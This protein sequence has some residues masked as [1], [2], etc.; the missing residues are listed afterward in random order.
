M[1]AD[2]PDS[3][4]NAEDS[5]AHL[6]RDLE[7]IARSGTESIDAR[8]PNLDQFTTPDLVAA[9]V[10]DQR[11]AVEAVVRAASAIS[12]AVDQAVVR[13]SR[14]GRLIYAG[15]GTSGRLAFLDA[16]EL[17]PTFS[18][19][20]SRALVCMAGGQDA[21]FKAV[22][23]AEDNLEAGRADVSRLNPAQDD[24]IIGIA[25]SGTTP[26][27][28]GAFIAGKSVGALTI[29]I[30]NNADTPVLAAC[31][32]PIALLTG[33]EVIS[34]STRLKAGS[35]QKMTLNA[36][37]SGI[38]VRLNKV[39]GNLMVDLQ[40]TNAKLIQRA[41]R[42]TTIATGSSPPDARAALEACG[43]NVKTAIVMLKAELNAAD[44][45][46]CL[47]RVQGSVR[48]ALEQ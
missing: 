37:S 39:Y 30:A 13:L 19:P 29:G 10:E 42:L 11:N 45:R 33:P 20:A 41:I 34:G 31:D 26:Y 35:A 6:E 25:A 17:T 48:Q 28:L 1:S 46:E 8:Y 4:L 3:I 23:G 7:R 15:A 18:W 12:S 22:E 9:L 27:V 36:L 16:A 32:L 24:V 44:A 14:G 43:W 5:A 47:D 40:A 38:M 2:R 21:V